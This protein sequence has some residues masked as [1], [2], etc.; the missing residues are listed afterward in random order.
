MSL[1]MFDFDGVIVDSLEVVGRAFQAACLDNGYVELEKLQDF[2]DLFDDNVYASL[3]DR[4]LADEKI[5]RILKNYKER[6]GRSLAGLKAFEGIGAALERIMR[7]NRV[8]II[9]SNLTWETG[10]VLQRNGISGY[11]EIIGA[12]REKSKI[13]KI[14]NT[15]KRYR[16]TPAYYVGDT[17]GDMI[18]GKEAGTLTVAV[19]WGWHTRDKL[20]EGGPDY[21]VDTPGE[22]AGLLE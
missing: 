8:V 20:L 9:T 11:E 18:E 3:R 22:L 2:V 12:D 15:K 21:I 1:V 7:H 19:T 13:K 5:D 6:V 17:K 10:Q 16:E 14:L 4:G